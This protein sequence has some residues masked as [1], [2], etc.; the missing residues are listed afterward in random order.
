MTSFTKRPGHPLH[1]RA[2]FSRSGEIKDGV[3]DDGCRRTEGEVRGGGD[4]AWLIHSAKASPRPGFVQAI[5]WCAAN[6]SRPENQR[7]TAEFH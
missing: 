5:E 3:A 7:F 6:L 1:S 4:E 2:N